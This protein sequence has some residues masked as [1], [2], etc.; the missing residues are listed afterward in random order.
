MLHSS[1]HE[2][3]LNEENDESYLAIYLEDEQINYIPTKDSGYT[4]DLE[5][6]SC[7][8][9]VEL[10]FDYN[11]WTIKTNYSNYESTDNTRVKC[12]LYFRERTFAEAV[13]DCGSLSKNAGTCITENYYLTDEV[14]DDETL[15]HNLRFI[16]ADPNNYVLYNDELWRIIG[17]MNNIDDGTGAKETRLKIIRNESIGEYSWDYNSDGTYDNDWTTSTLMNLLNN[18]AYYNRTTGS[19]YN[20]STT[21]T[22]VDF[23]SNGLTSEAKSMIGN[24]IW[25]LGGLPTDAYNAT[26]FYNSERGNDVYNN[27]SLKWIGN[28]GLM[29]VSD[30]AYATNGGG[31]IFDYE[32]CLSYNLG[33]QG[34]NSYDECYLNDWLYNLN[35]LL[36]W[37]MTATSSEW[38]YIYIN[39]DTSVSILQ[40]QIPA[41]VFPAA[42]LSTNVKITSGTGSS[43]DPFILS[44]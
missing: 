44:L 12:S 8:N 40:A 27:N 41:S 29:Y 32:S 9:G 21:A 13:V 37:T 18:G 23:S 20:G 35:V 19:Y 42:Y 38:S 36:R 17:V 7:N 14:V 4:L 22:D 26:Y 28:I 10:D 6:S 15:D 31:N 16:G 39:Y 3:I 24:A 34:W 2:T 25:N 43:S 5:K 30:Y 11:T 1:N 33:S